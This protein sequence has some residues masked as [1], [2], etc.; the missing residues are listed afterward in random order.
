MLDNDLYYDVYES[1]I[2]ARIEGYELPWVPNLSYPDSP[3]DKA[4]GDMLEACERICRRLGTEE[5]GD[6]E[7]IR[8]AY[9]EMQH[10]LCRQMFAC[11]MTYANM[12][13]NRPVD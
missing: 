9:E 6:V 13:K 11:G 7:E 10:L 2:G 8:N 4:Y 3:F 5:D 12:R 1:M